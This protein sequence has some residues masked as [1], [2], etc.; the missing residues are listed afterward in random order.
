[1]CSSP[2]R[3]G[4]GRP[5]WAVFGRLTEH[6][7]T[8][9][10]K[11]KFLDWTDAKPPSPKNVS[12]SVPEQKVLLLL[13][14]T[15]QVALNIVSTVPK[16]RANCILLDFYL[17]PVSQEAP[18]RACRPYDATLML[19]VLQS[20]V[21]TVLDGV[22]VG[23]GYGPVESEDLMRTLEI[24]TV[25]VDVWHILE[26]DYSRLPRQSIGQFHEGDAYVVKWKYMV[27]ASG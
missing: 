26:F 19:P 21:S 14:P 6:N 2:H 20:S 15:K 17:H 12:E 7:E 24:S 1:M 22:N 10:F 23:R 27:S 4:Q 16:K 5:D 18:G 8:V 11:E 25:A 13:T 9:L 3:K